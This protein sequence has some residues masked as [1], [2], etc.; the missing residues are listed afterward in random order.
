MKKGLK[1]A[2]IINSIF[3]VFAILLRIVF[4]NYEDGIL[5]II[6]SCVSI[7]TLVFGI[8]YAISGYKKN[9]AKFYKTFMGAYLF[10]CVLSLVTLASYFISIGQLASINSI[11]ALL[12]IVLSIFASYKL[13]FGL[14]LGYKKSQKLAL[15]ILLSNLIKMIVDL[16][17]KLP[18]SLPIDFSNLIF[19]CILMVFVL[20]KYLEKE[21]RGT[22]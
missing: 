19:S 13:C 8:I 14:D 11:L 15:I 4:F 5:V 18:M 7:A 6:D 20:G 22:K 16:L 21:N 1:L 3:I 12:C 10:S 9:A 17:F 2:G